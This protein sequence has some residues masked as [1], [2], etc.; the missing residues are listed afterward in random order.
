MSI[1]VPLVSYFDDE[2]RTMKNAA[3]VRHILFNKLKLLRGRLAVSVEMPVILVTPNQEAKKGCVYVLKPQTLDIFDPGKRLTNHGSF[4]DD[5]GSL[6]RHLLVDYQ[7]RWVNKNRTMF[8]LSRQSSAWLEHRPMLSIK[9]WAKSFMTAI[10]TYRKSQDF[11]LKLLKGFKNYP[12][13]G[14]LLS[15]FEI[16]CLPK[17]YKEMIEKVELWSHKLF[18]MYLFHNDA[19]SHQDL[20]N[21]LTWAACRSKD[22]WAKALEELEK[23]KDRAKR[24]EFTMEMGLMGHTNLPQL[25]VQRMCFR[26]GDVLPMAFTFQTE[27]TKVPGAPQW[28]KEMRASTKQYLEEFLDKHGAKRDTGERPDEELNAEQRRIYF[29][30]ECM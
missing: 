13:I 28:G 29:C 10:Q 6:I 27:T 23:G 30:L 9:P 24:R 17:T 12:P 25:L 19:S 16:Q 3:Q 15:E 1:E 14:S 8:K 2:P 20:S 26:C 21:V 4:F 22:Q 18:Y 7:A 5:R 11:D